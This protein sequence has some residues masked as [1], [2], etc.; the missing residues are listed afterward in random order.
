M[1]PAAQ[2]ST[3]GP[4]LIIKRITFLKRSVI[5]YN[6]LVMKGTLTHTHTQ[7]QLIF[8]G[9]HRLVCHKLYTTV[10]CIL[11]QDQNRPTSEIFLHSD[12]QGPTCN[13]SEIRSKY[14][15]LLRVKNQYFCKLT[16]KFSGLMSL[17]TIFNVCR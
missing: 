9:Q 13:K 6:K 4:Y 12:V 10:P 16:N 5:L 7:F 11:L 15:H 8:R 3:L 14:I 1:T 2:T 17:W